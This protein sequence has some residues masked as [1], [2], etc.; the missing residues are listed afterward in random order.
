MKPIS[1]VFYR[2]SSNILYFTVIP[3]F[4]FLFTLAY[5]PFETADFLAVGN[6]LFV[7]NLIFTS[8]IL[9]G[10]MAVSR[11]LLY[12]LRN[13]LDL[14]WLQY[15]LWCLGEIVVAGLFWSILLGHEWGDAVPYITV[16]GTG[17]MYLAGI[18]IFP[19]TILTLAIQIYALSGGEQIA[20]EDEKTLVRFHDDQKRL[21]FIVSSPA[22]LYIESED[23]YVHIVHLD[24]GRVKDFTLRSSMRAL[25]ELLGK[26]GLV[27]CH[28]SYFVNPNHVE[29]V[30]KDIN[31]YALAQLDRSGLQPVPVSRKYYESLSSL[32]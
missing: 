7:E 31:G 17:I 21:K 13:E 15:I 25:E 5:Q 18:A 9:L 19:Y 4:F 12:V 11:M 22:I 26:H 30:K 2:M 27:R 14:N 24:N 10:V 6:G 32:L 16:L 20:I 1:R 28:R 8:L 3:L 29:M 23:N